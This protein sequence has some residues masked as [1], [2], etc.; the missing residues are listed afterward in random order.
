MRAAI[1]AA[2]LLCFLCYLY[3][4][5]KRGRGAGW[6]VSCHPP[7]RD[8]ARAAVEAQQQQQ[9]RAAQTYTYYRDR[10]ITLLSM[11]QAAAVEE[12]EARENLYHIRDLNQYGQVIPKKTEDRAA[13]LLYTAQRKRL[14]IAAQLEQT[15]RGKQK[16]IDTIQNNVL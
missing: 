12:E 11:L 5:R 3:Q 7:D 8:R 1:F 16:T 2:T 4:E 13:R 14:S 10:E 15:R 6:I 9:G